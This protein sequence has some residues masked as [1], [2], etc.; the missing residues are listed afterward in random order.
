MHLWSK[1]INYRLQ[2]RVDYIREIYEIPT[3]YCLQ[4]KFI[5]GFRELKHT[6][7][8]ETDLVKVHI[9]TLDYSSHAANFIM[10]LISK[11]ISKIEDSFHSNSNRKCHEEIYSVDPILACIWSNRLDPLN[12]VT[13]IN[14]ME[15][16]VEVLLLSPFFNTEV[17]RTFKGGN[18]CCYIQQILD[19]CGDVRY[20]TVFL[21]I[22]LSEYTIYL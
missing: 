12:N 18:I 13:V 20:Q 21:F 4:L 11:I 14:R 5:H 22:L 1:Y 7:I 17:L 16:K 8:Q 10:D 9:Y 15:H 19:T 3:D 6:W 2:L